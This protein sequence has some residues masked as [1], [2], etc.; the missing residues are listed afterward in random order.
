MRENDFYHE[1]IFK[2]PSASYIS[3]QFLQ[4]LSIVKEDLRKLFKKCHT[5]RNKIFCES[6][7]Q[8]GYYKFLKIY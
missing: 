6:G 7:E 2:Q 3:L 5:L 8:I 1:N 4:S